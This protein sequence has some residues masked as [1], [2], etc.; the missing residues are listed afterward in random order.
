VSEK[1]CNSQD[2]ILENGGQNLKKEGIFN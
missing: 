1:H 2:L